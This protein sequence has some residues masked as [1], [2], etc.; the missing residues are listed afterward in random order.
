N[1]QVQII[2][3]AFLTKEADEFFPPRSKA[4]NPSGIRVGVS[5]PPEHYL[6]FQKIN[7][8]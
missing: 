8:A 7:K 4:V 5:K 2:T 3:Y 6:L 1:E